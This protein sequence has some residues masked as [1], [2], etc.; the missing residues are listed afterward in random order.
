MVFDFVTRVHSRNNHEL[1]FYS[2][3]SI[4]LWARSCFRFISHS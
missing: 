1:G 4:T 3:M 2:F